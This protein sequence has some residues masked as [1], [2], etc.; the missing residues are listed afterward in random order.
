MMRHSRIELTMNTYTDSRLLDTS[1]AVESVPLLRTLAP[2]LGT[3]LSASE[4]IR[5]NY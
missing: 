5:V 3:K 2:L 4:S 1:T